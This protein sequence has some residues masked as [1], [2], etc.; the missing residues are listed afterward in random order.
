VAEFSCIQPPGF[1]LSFFLFAVA[2]VNALVVPLA[3][4]KQA[5]IAPRSQGIFEYEAEISAVVSAGVAADKTMY[6]L[7][8]EYKTALIA[9]S[10][11]TAADDDGGDTNSTSNYMSKMSN[12][13]YDIDKLLTMVPC[14]AADNCT[15]P[16]ST[17]I[18]AALRHRQKSGAWLGETLSSYFASYL[19]SLSGR[20]GDEGDDDSNSNRKYAGPL[21]VPSHW[22]VRLLYDLNSG[23]SKTLATEGVRYNSKDDKRELVIDPVRLATVLFDLQPARTN[24]SFSGG[25]GYSDSGGSGVKKVDDHQPSSP[26]LLQTG[27]DA[28]DSVWAAASAAALEQYNKLDLSSKRQPTELEIMR[29]A[30]L[31]KISTT[32]A[33]AGASSPPSPARV[34]PRLYRNIHK[35]VIEMRRMEDEDHRALVPLVESA[36]AIMRLSC[37]RWFALIGVYLGY[38]LFR[39]PP[40]AARAMI[41]FVA[42][43]SRIFQ[44]AILLSFPAVCW[45]YG[46]GMVFSSFASVIFWAGPIIRALEHLRSATASVAPRDW[47]DATEAEFE[48]MGGLCAI[49]WG[50]LET[51]RPR[52]GGGSP[53]AANGVGNGRAMATAD[54]R[55]EA[56]VTA[57]GA[58]I[59]AAGLTC[60]HAYHRK[61]IVGWLQS[62]Y[63][64]GRTPTCPMCQSE[65]PVRI[66]FKLPLSTNA[67]EVE[68]EAENGAAAGAGGNNNA[69]EGGAGAGAGGAG[70]HRREPGIPGLDMLVDELYEE[71]R[72]RFEPPMGV[73]HVEINNQEGQRGQ[74]AAAAPPPPPPPQPAEQ[75]HVEHGGPNVAGTVH[76]HPDIQAILLEAIRAA[77]AAQQEG[78]LRDGEDGGGEPQQQEQQ[79]GGGPGPFFRLRFFN[80][81][82]GRQQP[83][84]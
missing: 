47:H 51:T 3:I 56:T 68:A 17:E 46:A 52:S 73:A 59:R 1:L 37:E 54:V 69:A 18:L 61:C 83:P 11:K 7:E 66:K 39:D 36:L 62:C 41:R 25:G 33:K 6:Y 64:Q 22:A 77:E 29:E 57:S 27:M 74:A 65:V 60:G 50:D 58:S 79:R 35:H 75:Q 72:H 80:R 34:L 44:R 63:G 53:T 31:N 82:G 21:L 24:S 14:V 8:K 49:C 13:R 70:V 42:H 43:V 48:R 5:Y 12:P 71:F 16:L 78:E 81:Q 55:G 76:V 20:D 19:S 2:A 10:K 40:P 30:Y 15:G 26:S 23:V 32:A 38:L 67:M 45:I 84:L 28:L 4:E 9:A